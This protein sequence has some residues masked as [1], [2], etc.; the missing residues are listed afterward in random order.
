MKNTLKKVLLGF[1]A[2][3]ALLV[4]AVGVEHRIAKPDPVGFDPVIVGELESAMW[5]SYYEGRWWGLTSQTLKLASSQFGYSW[6]DSVR[7]SWFAASAARYFRHDAHDA[8]SIP[9]LTKYY[10]II[11]SGLHGSFEPASAAGLELRWWQQRR[12]HASSSE[13]A[14]TLSELTAVV[15]DAPASAFEAASLQRVEAM[16]Y[17]DARRDRKMSDE[18]WQEIS[19]QLG[20]AYQSFLLAANHD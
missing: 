14:A 17:R 8:R 18:D 9:L 3:A 2:A 7:M 11:R 13:I 1:I 20:V 16:E 15:F 10:S 12:E 4:A 5:R 19:R 6:W